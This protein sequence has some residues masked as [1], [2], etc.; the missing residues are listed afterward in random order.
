MERTLKY[1]PR[2]FDL[3]A[4]RVC[5]ACNELKPADAFRLKARTRFRRCRPCEAAIERERRKAILSMSREERERVFGK[6]PE[7]FEPFWRYVDKG[8][9]CWLWNGPRTHKGYGALQVEI[10]GLTYYRAHRVSWAIH[11]GEIPDDLHVLHKCNNPWC[12]NPEH[13]RLGTNAEN[14]EDR[15]RDGRQITGER[16]GRAKLT[17][18]LVRRIRQDDR[19]QTEWAEELGVHPTTIGNIRAGK[20]WRHVN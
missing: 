13:L 5:V 1:L 17:P 15:K 7:Y 14:V 4:P 18:E 12:V 11:N 8:G 19:P 20:K 6:Q 9:S 3:D 2:G 10:A 16:N